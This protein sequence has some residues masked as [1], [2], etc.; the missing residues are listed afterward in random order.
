[1]SRHANVQVASI[2]ATRGH[3]HGSPAGKPGGRW[4]ARGWQ[5]CAVVWMALLVLALPCRA[6]DPALVRSLKVNYDGTTYVADATLFAP[7]AVPLAWDVLT[8]F[9]HQPGWVPN[10]TDSKVVKREASSVVVDQSG[11]ATF[12]PLSVPYVTER[13]IDMDKPV[14]ITST[15]LKGNLKRVVSTIK[16]EADP[17]G[18][19]IAYHIEVIPNFL[20]STVMSPAFFEHEIPEQFGAIVDE[21]KRRSKQAARAVPAEA[22]K[23]Q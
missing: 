13:R 16:L 17:G 18:T 11:T 6:A 10:L 14:A 3:G 8:D 22:A 5:P 2:V 7:V 1:M 12:G 4:L 9:E 21:M 23:V 15:Q 19:V 20:A